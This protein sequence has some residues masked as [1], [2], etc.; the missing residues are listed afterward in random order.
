M[1]GLFSKA[2]WLQPSSSR[3]RAALFSGAC[4]LGAVFALLVVEAL[5]LF[6]TLQPTQLALLRRYADIPAR[7]AQAL[8]FRLAEGT[9]LI[10]LLVGVYFALGVALFV[11][12]TDVA[13]P[14]PSKARSL[15]TALGLLLWVLC[16][17]AMKFIAV[18]PA[19]AAAL[20]WGGRI[21]PW[22]RGFWSPGF[23]L[24][25]SCALGVVLVFALERRARWL[26]AA[27]RALALLLFLPL[28][29]PTVSTLEVG[30]TGRSAADV[31]FERPPVILIGIDALRRD[32]VSRWGGPRGLTP[33]LDQFLSESHE[34]KNAWTVVGRTHPSYVSL[35]TARTPDRHGVRYNRADPFFA[36]RLPKTL[37]HALIEAGYSTRYLTDENMFSSMTIDHGFQKVGV[38]PSMLETYATQKFMR[39]FF[40][41][42]LP[43]RLT[44]HFLP[45]LRHNR[46]AY[47]NYDSKDFSDAV[48]EALDDE[49]SS[50]QPFFLTAHLCTG[51]YPGT[52]PG[53]EF[54]AHQPKEAPL[55][56]Y[57]HASLRN[58]KDGDMH[59]PKERDVRL[60][61]LYRAGVQRVDAE[62]G[63]ILGHLRETGLLDKAWVVV[64]SD[65]GETFTDRMGKPIVPSHG[66]AVDEGG[67]DLKI[68]LAIRPPGGSHKTI[69]Q[70]VMSLDVGP[71]LLEGLGLPPLPG[72]REGR[73]LFSL[74]ESEPEGE[75]ILYA[76]SGT[77]YGRRLEKEA[78]QYDF[79]LFRL[80]R[81]D[82]N[83]G[84]LVTRRHFH[85]KLILNKQRMVQKGRFRLVYEPMADGSQRR[86][87]FDWQ[88]GDRPAV[89]LSKDHPQ[90]FEE[91]NRALES[92]LV[93]QE[94]E[95]LAEGVEKDG[96]APRGL[97]WL[98]RVGMPR[99]V[100]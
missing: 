77:H 61:G 11:Y 62:L 64:W 97:P 49:G 1:T 84:E 90:V 48:I 98:P 31:A 18:H 46:A 59:V 99:R 45:A 50:P 26:T 92:H 23:A 89:D 30:A 40:V 65:H 41:A 9:A 72:E 4:A 27:R 74:L 14:A 91:L 68:V 38:P 66:L 87:L 96:L 2:F 28:L 34:F 71:T 80:Y 21:E 70:T 20:P 32:H 56:N 44:S 88:A 73:A 24:L 35:L 63:R 55:V 69:E 33:H 51:H 82:P 93:D 54:R 6:G 36:Q 78:A 86:R 13:K 8:A 43:A 39:F 29:G 3:A 60:R 42:T 19:G 17:A 53:P 67:E 75:P 83:T 7:V 10:Y 85:D 79:D 58:L 57:F 47:H 76:E 81:F 16:S 5:G 15:G 37:G 94:P 22:L 12:L 52:H 25:G 100:P 95:K